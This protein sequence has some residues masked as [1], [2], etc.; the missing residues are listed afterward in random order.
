MQATR[1]NPMPECCF[2]AIYFLLSCELNSFKRCAGEKERV[3]L[4]K[5]KKENKTFVFSLIE[6]IQIVSVKCQLSYV[7]I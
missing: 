7:W 3:W 2:I 6:S 1:E 4:I 5:N